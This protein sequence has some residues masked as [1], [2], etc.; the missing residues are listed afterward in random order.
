VGGAPEAAALVSFQSLAALFLPAEPAR[1]GAVVDAGQSWRLDPSEV[2]D[3]DAV[4][5]GRDALRSG[6]GA[7]EGMAWMA[8]RERAIARLRIHPPAGLQVVGAHRLPPARLGV[9]SIMNRLRDLVR[10]GALIELWRGPRGRRAIDAAARSAGAAELFGFRPGSGGSALARFRAADGTIGVMR[11]GACGRAADPAAAAEALERLAPLGLRSVP[12]LTGRGDVA[13]VG[14][15]TETLLPGRAPG[16]LGPR[17]AMQLASFCAALPLAEGPPRAHLAHL[18]TLAERFPGREAALLEAR[19]ACET[20]GASVP[21]ILGHGDLWTG[22][23]LAEHDTL[24]GVVDWDAWNHAA[25]PGTDLLHAMAVDQGRRLGLGIGG[26]WL[27]RPWTSGRFGRVAASY[28]RALDITAGDSFLGAV[29][30]AWWAGQVAWTVERLPRLA[31][32]DGWVSE[33]VDAV[34]ATLAR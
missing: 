27:R 7:M 23:L 28:W 34:L 3:A 29:G 9:G 22:N 18:A 11:L 31:T 17:L 13:G 1:R 32:E 26:V 6:R 24:T 20:A 8:G 2:P 4:V 5:W 16:V 19:T 14:W 25:F 12:R 10:S 21:G 15:S 30:I 33:N